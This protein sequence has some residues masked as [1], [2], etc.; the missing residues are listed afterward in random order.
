MAPVQ[1][2]AVVSQPGKPKGRGN[3]A[4]PVPSPVEQLARQHLPSEAILCPK[5][6]KE[7]RVMTAR[8][9]H[10]SLSWDSFYVNSPDR[11]P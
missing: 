5:S 1:V 7:V 11:R 10:H 2:A 3:K 6:A 9:C 8:Q 4:V